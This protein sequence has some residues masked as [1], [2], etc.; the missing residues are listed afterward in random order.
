[1]VVGDRLELLRRDKAER[2]VP[3]AAITERLDV[4]ED[5]RPQFAADW[6]GAAMDELL[7]QGC[8]EPLGDGVIEAIAASSHRLGDAGGAACWPNASDTN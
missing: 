7:L 6:P 8:V 3:A 4:V 5:F 1:M 2:A